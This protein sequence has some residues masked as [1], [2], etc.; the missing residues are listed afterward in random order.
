MDV[1]WIGDGEDRLGQAGRLATH[2]GRERLM[3]GDFH[4]KKEEGAAV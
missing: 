4:V 2:S 1:R 3:R